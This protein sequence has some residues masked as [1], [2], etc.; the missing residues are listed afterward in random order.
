[1]PTTLPDFR[2]QF[3]LADIEQHV[4]AYW[5]TCSAEDK[6]RET[7]IE[8]VIA[9]SMRE[10]RYLTKEDFA[11]IVR[12]KSPRSITY[13]ARNDEAFVEAVTH[14]ALTTKHE[15]LRIEVLTLLSGVQWPV[16][17]AILHFGYDNLYP[18]LDVRALGAAGMDPQ[19]VTYD[20]NLWWEYTIFCRRTA[21][22]AGVTMR[23]L[24]QAL[25]GYRAAPQ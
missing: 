25:W 3:P 14:T 24:D 2:L 5:A 21:Q 11:K 9:L 7:H 4:Y 18:I 6:T 8:T 12:W 10:H 20:F 23:E 17:S 13:A 1:M 16:A 19:A 15:R 22:E